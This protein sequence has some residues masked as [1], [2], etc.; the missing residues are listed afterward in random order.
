MIFDKCAKYRQNK[1]AS[2]KKGNIINIKVN[3]KG[4]LFIPNVTERCI[5]REFV[6]I[7]KVYKKGIC[8]L[9]GYYG[10]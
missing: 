4:M 10:R 8:T 1:L 7:S 6:I 2:D 3:K 5:E 9:W